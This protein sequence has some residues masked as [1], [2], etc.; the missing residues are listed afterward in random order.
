VG[1][2]GIREA[3]AT[4]RGK[5]TL[6]ARCEIEE[7]PSGKSLIVVHEIPF[8]ENK[9]RILE[10]ILKLSVDQKDAL[11]CISDIRDESDR[12]GM[13]AVI[14]VKKGA[15][16]GKIL[17]YLYRYSPLQVT[18]G[19]NMVAIAGG[20]PCQLSLTQILD[21]YIEHQKAVVTRRTRFELEHAEAREHILEGLI[22]A[23]A[24]ID[25]VVR[26]IRASKTTRDAQKA[27]MQ[28]FS[29]TSVQAQ[30]ILDL[31]LARLTAL[32]VEK[33]EQELAEVRTTIA[34]LR[35]IL[36]S[37]AKL[38]SV[39]RGE[40]QAIR[41]AYATPRKTKILLAEKPEEFNPADYVVVEDCVVTV[42]AGGYVK[43]LPAKTYQR[44]NRESGMDDLTPGDRPLALLETNTAQRLFCFTQGGLMIQLPVSDVPEARWKDKGAHLS[45]LVAAYP[46]REACVGALCVGENLDKGEL[47]FITEAG[48]AKKTALSEYATRQKKLVACSVKEGD[49]LVLAELARKG[50]SLVLVTRH[51]YLLSTR[52]SQI[53]AQ[54]RATRGVKAMELEEGDRLLMAAQCAPEEDLALL[55]D[56][57][58]GRRLPVMEMTSQ[59]RG[60]RGSRAIQFYKNGAN[61]RELA[62]ACA[63][64]EGD[65]LAVTQ[66]SGQVTRMPAAA[67]SSA[68][69]ES[70]GAPTELLIMGD[71]IVSV[72]RMLK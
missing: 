25:E 55:T 28:R 53:P 30:A 19:V 3:Y 5:I 36:A 1:E 69:A 11:G 31:R 67:V 38:L 32:E 58:Y 51:G 23:V 70:R 10:R 26:I 62:G 15:D 71:P 33:L 63:V 14:E 29:L 17:Q 66:A 59:N 65:T 54:G 2:E 57:G 6:R 12:N 48:M 7:G 4:G 44:S 45:T 50:T 42:T 16:A 24:N 64:G 21:A 18:Y 43:R 37:K 20:K 61:G 68:R 72:Y 52:H 8:Q 35:A 46:Q 56:T 9:A 39:I 41:K 49:T 22:I 60:G 34:N 13:R 27:L 47:V 40:L